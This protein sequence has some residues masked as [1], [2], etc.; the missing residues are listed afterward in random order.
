MRIHSSIFSFSSCLFTLLFLLAPYFLFDFTIVSKYSSLVTNLKFN[1]VVMN[2]VKDH[3]VILLGESTIRTLHSSEEAVKED[4]LISNLSLPGSLGSENIEVL[5]KALDRHP[6][7]NTLIYGTFLPSS[8]ETSGTL[9][10][11]IPG[12]IS[13][14]DIWRKWMLGQLSVGEGLEI[15]SLKMFPILTARD[16]V[17]QRGYLGAGMDFRDLLLIVKEK[18][19]QQQGVQGGKILNIRNPLE[20]F[21][22]IAKER[23][24]R[25]VVM[26]TPF[27][28]TFRGQKKFEVLLQD[29][30]RICQLPLECWD[31]SEG[32]SDDV[33]VE[34]GFH[35]KLTGVQP[36]LELIRDRLNRR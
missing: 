7:F 21:L 22:K 19:K 1:R 34:D 16:E 6:D 4:P 31:L 20:E 35:Y 13:L 11:Y 12:I 24:M 28:S 27:S 26:L 18:R 30:R 32:L 36:Y 3:K 17:L 23:K 8:I 33:F 9:D 14:E 2:H 15:V 10:R 5:M 25:F 29:F